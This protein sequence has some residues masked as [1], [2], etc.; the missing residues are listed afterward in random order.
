M[1]TTSLSWANK[2]ITITKNRISLLQ[3]KLEKKKKNTCLLHYISIPPN[4]WWKSLTRAK[5][6]QEELFCS[7]FIFLMNLSLLC[8]HSC[9]RDC[10]ESCSDE[11]GRSTWLAALQTDFKPEGGG[12][13]L[14]AESCGEN[15]MK[16]CFPALWCQAW[17]CTMWC[18]RCKKAES[19]QILS[20]PPLLLNVRLVSL[21][22]P[23]CI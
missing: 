22:I 10:P 19:L 9:C 15:Q 23:M 7:A 11:P 13:L 14:V 4:W 20:G 18:L 2:T 1:L 21:Q 8:G 12:E 5:W 16:S 3:S 17:K 6:D